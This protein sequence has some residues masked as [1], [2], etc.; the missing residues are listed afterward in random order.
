M[1]FVER[2]LRKR[3]PIGPDFFADRFRVTILCTPFDEFVFHLVEYRLLLFTH[4]LSQY[5][6]IT[7]TKA[8]Q[9]LRKQHYLLLVNGDTIRLLEEFFHF[10]QIVFDR[11]TTVLPVNELRNVFHRARAI[12][13]VHRD[14]IFELIGLQLAQVFLHPH[15][16]KLECSG[17]FAPLEKLIGFG[18]R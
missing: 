8:S 3:F 9:L 6:G 16:F 4:R 2:I 5:I 18:I 11:L 12:Q 1:R 13:R 10:R 15:T 17:C 14:Q 7:F